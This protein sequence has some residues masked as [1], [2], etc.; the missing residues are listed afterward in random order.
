MYGKK[1]QGALPRIFLQSEGIYKN[2]GQYEKYRFAR[3]F[4]AFYKHNVS[5]NAPFGYKRNKG[6]EYK[7][8]A[9]PYQQYVCA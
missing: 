9:L 4:G 7:G 2:D 5:Q 8:G 6:T 1:I 3:S